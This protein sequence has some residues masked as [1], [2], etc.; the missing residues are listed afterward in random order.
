M[1]PDPPIGLDALAQAAD[2]LA[3]LLELA[4]GQRHRAVAAGFSVAVA[5]MMAA[6]VHAELVNLAFQSTLR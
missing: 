1:T 2:G 5:E 6:Q 4:V 3:Q